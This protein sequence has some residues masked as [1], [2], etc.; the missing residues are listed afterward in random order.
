MTFRGLLLRNLVYHWRGNLAILCGVAVG[1]AVLTGALLVGDSL[2]GSL[3]DQVL[4]QLGWVDHALVAGRFFHEDLADDLGAERIS[5]AILLR[6]AATRGSDAT[7]PGSSENQVRRAGRI[8]I[9]GVDR[10]FWGDTQPS[11]AGFW[12]SKQEEVVLNRA[13]ASELG[14]QTGDTVTVHLQKI[15]AVPRESLLGRRDASEVI[16]ALKLT[17]RAIIPDEGLGRFSLN[18]SMETPRNAFVPL[19]TLQAVLNQKGRVNALLARGGTGLQEKLQQ[20]LTLAQPKARPEPFA[21]VTVERLDDWGLLVKEPADREGAS[22]PYLSL[23]S[24]QMMIEPAAAKAA[25]QAA[26]EAGLRT[27][28]TLVYLANGISDGAHQIPYSVVAALDPTLAPPLGPFLPRNVDNL[29]DDEIVLVDWKESPLQ[30]KPGDKIMLTYFKPEEEG[31]LPEVSATFTLKA[32]IPLEGAAKDPH[33]TP[34]FPGITDKLAIR[35][36]NPPFPFDNKRIQKRDERYWEQY[37]ATPKAYVTLAAG[38]RMWGSRFGQL[39]SIRLASAGQ[40]TAR[41]TPDVTDTKEIFSQSLLKHLS[42]E[43]AG[44][45]FDDVRERGLA[46][47]V[48][49]TDFGMYFLG[50]SSFLIVA[51]LLLVGLLFRLNLDRRGSELGL[52]LAAGYRRVQLGGLMLAEGLILSVFGGLIGVLGAIGYAWM[53]LDLLRSWWPGAIDRSFLH[54]HSSG[55]SLALGYG[56]GLAASALTILWAVRVLSR[57]S[58]RSLLAGET[59]GSSVVEYGVGRRTWSRWLALGGAVGALSL[60]VTGRFIHD[61]ESQAMTF[62]GS[63]A[64][65]LT[66]SLAGVWAWMRSSRHQR[67]AGHGVAAVARLGFGNAA[68]NPVRSL[69]TAGLLASAVFVVAATE[70]FH[71]NA[72]AEVIDPKSGTGGFTLLAESNLPIYQD[73]NSQDGRFEL[74]FADAATAILNEV[75]F[76]SFRLRAGDD[77]SCLNLY[78]PNR[79]LVLGVP[80]ALISLG[81]FRFEDSE[82]RTAE[83]KENPWKLLNGDPT[84]AIPAIGDATTL[85]YI[86]QSKLGGTVDVPNQQGDSKKLRIV[87]LL[88]DSIF[89][90]QLLVSESNFQKL[91]PKHEG[92]N[93][94]LIDAPPNKATAVKSLL[95]STLAERGFE[96]TPTARRLEAYWAVENTYLATFQLL[97]GLGLVLGAL[98]LAVVLLRTVWE[99]R[100][101]LA[102]LRALGFRRS[103]LGWLVL[104]E[105]S[106]LLALG[107][108]VGTVSALLAVIP[109]WHSAGGELSWMRLV[110]LLA[111][112]LGVGFVAGAAAVIT[113]LRAPLLPALRRE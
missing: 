92:Y 76:Y 90:S 82:T 96:V 107:I 62:F 51:A 93:F 6:G 13:L 43:A 53:L 72:P 71:R 70:S 100:G 101:E 103:A 85:Q 44:L 74:N 102:L 48:S 10:R 30:A 2:R 112:V 64:L 12:Q 67:V 32:L 57:V 35:D 34:E 18:P 66:A 16:D 45:V 98:G 61:H 69:L 99:R 37:R 106:L 36:W 24:R 5:P 113:S 39:T 110:V 77:A 38:Q 29:R 79:P 109:H 41:P 56:G 54:L 40:P 60:M 63:G 47:S 1:T 11:D 68:R 97:G 91:Y 42:P 59:T 87:G 83:E 28:P 15:S 9:L 33:L 88:A 20:N 84:D 65:L 80:S 19:R 78:R 81:R 89:Q 14:A 22:R 3:R 111:L 86:L 27:A 108:A 21:D 4:E 52:L 25:E 8:T 95:E 17:V 31:R 104:A 58:P 50:F 49:S 55:S 26:N 7:A 23:E 75:H 73:L 94:F 105:N 46:T